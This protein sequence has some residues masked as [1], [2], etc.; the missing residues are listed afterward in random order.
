M[1]SAKI[2]SA[3][4]SNNLFVANKLASFGKKKHWFLQ[5]Q[6]SAA[7]KSAS[8]DRSCP[9]RPPL[10]LPG[11]QR[12]GGEEYGLAYGPLPWLKKR[13]GADGTTTTEEIGEQGEQLI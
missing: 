10:K 3:E 5:N 7:N 8:A 2:S 1:V 13:L 9:R 6:I 4:N 11:A 12:G